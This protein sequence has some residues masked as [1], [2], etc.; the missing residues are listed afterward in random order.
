M[1]KKVL[2][3][4]GS[5][6]IG[7]C[8]G[9]MFVSHGFDVRSFSPSSHTVNLPNGIIGIVGSIADK[10]S[11]EKQIIWADCIMHFVSTTNPISSAK[12]PYNDVCSNLLPLIQLLDILKIYPEKKFIFCSSGGAVYGNSLNLLLDEKA[13]RNPKSSYGIVKCAMEDY[14]SYY[15]NIYNLDVLIIRPSNIYG[16]KHSSIGQQGVI[17]T[18]ISNALNNKVSVI[19]SSMDV[20]K[21][22][23]F[24]DDFAKAL[25]LLIINNASGIFN[26]GYGETF[27]LNKII[28]EIELVLE[29]PLNIEKKTGE[30]SLIDVPV[31][32]DISK[33]VAFI[34]WEPEIELKDGINKINQFF[35][36]Q[37]K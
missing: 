31:K 34:N 18:L 26:I 20:G 12:D 1:I 7:R 3:I 6:F 21:D 9:E 23:L 11:I 22:Y 8:I 14:I 19:W 4:G 24:V 30:Y 2:I 33:M 27:T 10:E 29:K 16:P 17:S 32:L 35:L 15:Q 28:R 37:I 25:Y 5:G 13:A 36:N